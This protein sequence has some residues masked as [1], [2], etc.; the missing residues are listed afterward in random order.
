LAG[1][2]V[3][4]GIVFGARFSPPDHPI[5]SFLLARRLFLPPVQIPVDLRPWR[6]SPKPSPKRPDVLPFFP[7]FSCQRPLPS[8]LCN[9]IPLFS[10]AQWG[11]EGCDW[12]SG[13]GFSWRGCLCPGFSR[14]PLFSFRFF[15][16]MPV[17]G[18]FR[19]LGEKIKFRDP[20]R[21][22]LSTPL[23]FGFLRLF[24]TSVQLFRVYSGF[25][26]H[27]RVIFPVQCRACCWTP[28]FFAWW[29]LDPDSGRQ[30][31][32]TPLLMVESPPATLTLT[33]F[34]FCLSAEPFRNNPLRPS[35]TELTDI[36]IFHILCW[37]FLL[38]IPLEPLFD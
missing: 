7:F 35:I 20:R 6:D 10:T 26:A 14:Q 25:A 34:S 37:V 5:Q 28:S 23:S 9:L 36:Y 2:N 4:S 21:L 24:N 17:C 32:D 22:L 18:R 30:Q 8:S 38:S 16:F 11:I 3:F 27:G 33:P 29:I 15:F 31:A 12:F 13:G 19:F 1:Q